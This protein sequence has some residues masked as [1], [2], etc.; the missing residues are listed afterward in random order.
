MGLTK[1]IPFMKCIKVSPVRNV[2]IGF[3][4]LCNKYII[5]KWLCGSHLLKLGLP[6]RTHLTSR[7][8]LWPPIMLNYATLALF[9]PSHTHH[10][11]AMGNKGVTTVSQGW[12]FKICHVG[13]QSTHLHKSYNWISP[14]VNFFSNA[15]VA[16]VALEERRDSLW[17]KWFLKWLLL[18]LLAFYNFFIWKEN[19]LLKGY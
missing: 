2:T 14:N 13:R 19:Y 7:F 8:Y 1:G 16:A 3:L 9:P 4:C 5:L 18:K 10:Y 17:S 6:R 12:F 15:S 11:L